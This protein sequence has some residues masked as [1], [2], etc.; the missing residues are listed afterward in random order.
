MGF[1]GQRDAVKS[2]LTLLQFLKPLATSCGTKSYE[3][4]GG[5]GDCDS[6][7]VERYPGARVDLDAGLI[8]IPQAMDLQP[9]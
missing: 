3:T 4:P 7:V 1:L 9:E 6:V 8:R 2:T 5:F